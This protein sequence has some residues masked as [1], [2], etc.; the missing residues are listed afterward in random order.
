[1]SLVVIRVMEFK[2][3]QAG[4]LMSPA[5][6]KQELSDLKEVVLVYDEHTVKTQISH[7]SS[8]Q[9]KL[10]ELFNLDI[11]ESRLTIHSA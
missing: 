7:R 11:W 8:I 3:A 6:L 9:Q 5:V 2:V 1:M 10:S 4:L